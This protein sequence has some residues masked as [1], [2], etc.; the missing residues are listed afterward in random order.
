MLGVLPNERP[1]GG[2]CQDDEGDAASLQV[3]LVPDAPVGREQQLKLCRL[4]VQERAV[5]SVS[6]PFDCAVE[7]V[8][9]D[10][11]RASPFGVPWSK[12][13]STGVDVGSAQ[14]LSDELK[15]SGYLFARH[16]EL[17][18]DLVDAEILE[19]LDDRGHGQAGALEH[20]GAAHLA[21]D[22]LDR[23]TLGPIERCHGL[24][25]KLQLTGCRP[26]RHAASR[27]VLKRCQAAHP[28]CNLVPTGER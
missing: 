10:N 18:D 1:P 21:G 4:G 15:D 2:T 3:L 8:C 20:P 24:T 5:L 17:L 6:Q 25:S 28:A 9:P 12:R 14:A 13:M 11:A 22:A 7:T 19:V 26:G 23:G 16:V 27:S